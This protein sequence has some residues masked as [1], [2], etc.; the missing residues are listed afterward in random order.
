MHGTPCVI[1]PSLFFAVR[2]MS[3]INQIFR[4]L[5]II[6][7]GV[8]WGPASYCF[9]NDISRGRHPGENRGGIRESPVN[10]GFRVVLRVHGMTKRHVL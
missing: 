1:L 5:S 3:E 7:Y 10:T 4:F 9:G 6:T 2:D 8:Y